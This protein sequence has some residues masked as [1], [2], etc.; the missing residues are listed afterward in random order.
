MADAPAAPPVEPAT[1]V[2]PAPQP[3]PVPAAPAPAAPAQAAPAPAE[4]PAAALA[5]AQADLNEWKGFARKHER[6]SEQL[7]AQL[8]QQQTLLKTLAEKAGVEVDGKPDP[9]KLV[10]QLTA[11]RQT[12]Q[13]RARELAIFRAAAGANA[14]P[15]LLL[16]SRQFMA[17]TSGLDPSSTDFNDQVKALVAE[18]VAA[19]P[20]LAIAPP[21][22][23]AP[24]APAPVVPVASGA[25]FSGAPGG[26]RQ[27][28]E[29]DV[30]RASPEELTKAIAQGL[31]ADLGVGR[32]KS[33][34]R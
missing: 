3:A 15:D 24:A 23:P 29:E 34:W 28:T 8:E 1:A 27:W 21:A 4:D 12:A 16:D 26:N 9:E 2:A 18:T 20:T 22:A 25:D 11:A 33:T 31:T 30:K 10:A 19:N 14:N 7:A 6:T 5:K 32:R 17:K 13:D